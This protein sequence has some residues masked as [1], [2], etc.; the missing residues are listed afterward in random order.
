MRLIVTIE[1]ESGRAD[2]R[3]VLDDLG[4]VLQAGIDHDCLD[5][6]RILPNTA[7]EKTEAE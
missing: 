7:R 6:Y 2:I 4:D 1:V 3:K 5:D